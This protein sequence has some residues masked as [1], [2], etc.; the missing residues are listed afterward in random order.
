M[1]HASEEALLLHALDMVVLERGLDGSLILVGHAPG[2]FD[3]IFVPTDPLHYRDQLTANAPFLDTF[4]L[5]A[6]DFWASSRIR[7][8]GGQWVQRDMDG[9][10]RNIEAWAVNAG[11]R[12]FLVLKP[13]GAECDEARRVLQTFRNSKLA[14]ELSAAPRKPELRVSGLAGLGLVRSCLAV[15]CLSSLALFTLQGF[16]LWGFHLAIGLMNWVG[17]AC[18]ASII[19]LLLLPKGSRWARSKYSK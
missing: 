6:E 18:L 13:V 8:Y 3:R 11:A 5:D 7:L 1:I 19:S 15:I 17:L 2:W 16:T 10:D 12:R 4:L 9:L 14:D